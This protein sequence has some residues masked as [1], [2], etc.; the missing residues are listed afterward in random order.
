L[1]VEDKAVGQFDFNNP[2]GRKDKLR[3][4]GKAVADLC[5]RFDGE[6]VLFERKRG[7]KPK[8]DKVETPKRRRGRPP[9]DGI[10]AMPP[11]ERKRQERARKNAFK[12]AAE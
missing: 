7:R 1:A 9:K 3:L 4:I 6:K 2:V 10:A 5:K 11:K 8:E 12:I